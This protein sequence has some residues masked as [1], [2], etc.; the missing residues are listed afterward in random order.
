M[1]TGQTFRTHLF[2]MYDRTLLFAIL[3]KRCHKGTFFFDKNKISERN[4]AVKKKVN[5]TFLCVKPCYY[6]TFFVPLQ[7]HE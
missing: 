5:K 4:F 6:K 7:E 1:H 2:G 3:I